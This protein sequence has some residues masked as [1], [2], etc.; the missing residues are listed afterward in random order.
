[1]PGDDLA[2]VHDADFMSVGAKRDCL[3]RQ[4]WRHRVTVRVELDPGMR[5]GDRRHDL[6]GVE[7][8]R[9]KCAEQRSLF[10][11]TVYRAFSSRLMNPD[12]GNFVAPPGRERD[13]VLIADEFVTTAGQGISLHIAYA[14]L[15]DSFR[16]GIAPLASDR[17][18]AVVTAQCQELGVKTGGAA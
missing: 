16:F 10:L 6:V 15:D 9:G 3:A 2:L 13:I 12:V 11:E 7:R 4:V 1:M 5:A 17:L 8:D 14:G 18:D